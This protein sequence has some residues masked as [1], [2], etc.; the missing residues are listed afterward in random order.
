MLSIK[1]KKIFLDPELLRFPIPTDNHLLPKTTP[2]DPGEGLSLTP[3]GEIK[4]L[5]VSLIILSTAMLV[6]QKTNGMY[7]IRQRFIHRAETWKSF[8]QSGNLLTA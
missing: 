2:K 6:F 1:Q 7:W 3:C 5:A 8:R 4:P